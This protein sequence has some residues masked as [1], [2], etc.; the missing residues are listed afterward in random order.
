MNKDENIQKIIDACHQNAEKHIKAAEILIEQGQFN[1]GFHLALLALEEVGKAGMVF[2]KYVSLPAKKDS[3]W[4]DKR[5]DDHESK[6]FWAIWSENIFQP[7]NDLLENFHSMRAFAKEAHAN[8]LGAL[9]VDP[10]AL[11][12]GDNFLKEISRERALE[13]LNLAKEKLK[14]DKARKYT[15]LDQDTLDLYQWYIDAVSDDRLINYVYSDVSMNK[16]AELDNPRE[17]MQWIKDHVLNEEENLKLLTQME[18][19]RTQPEGDEIQEE[20]WKI[21]V[22]IKTQSHVFDPEELKKWN[23]GVRRLKINALG[24]K[25]S[26]EAILEITLPKIVPVRQLYGVG[27]TATVEILISLNLASLGFFWLYMPEC[28]GKYYEGRPKD[29][30]NPEASV[31]MGVK[32]RTPDWKIRKLTEIELQQAMLYFEV[33]KNLTPEKKQVLHSY[34]SGLIMLAGNNIFARNETIICGNFLQTLTRAMKVFGDWKEDETLKEACERE[35]IGVL[36]DKKNIQELLDLIE[37]LKDIDNIDHN[38]SLEQ[39]QSTK[40]LC[41]A[42]LGEKLQQ[43]ALSATTM[44]DHKDAE[45]DE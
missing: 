23:K 21:K 18:L 33:I 12:N 26:Q 29:L 6:I 22:K 41:D 27:L 9:Y 19:N 32:P 16:Y 4:I 2:S 31:E 42:Y 28:T 20:K 39:V 10:E 1:I 44:G 45:K 3:L 40:L 30:D 25:K 38:I 17:W 13:F 34:Y 7:G 14:L 11:K 24:K 35:L 36:Q 37:H 5:L 15:S 8:R 43:E